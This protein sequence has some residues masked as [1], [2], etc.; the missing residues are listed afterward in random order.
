MVVRQRQKQQLLSPSYY[1]LQMDCLHSSTSG[2]MTFSMSLFR[3]LVQF[4]EVHIHHVKP[5]T[6][7]QQL[8]NQNSQKM[9]NV[10]CKMRTLER[11]TLLLGSL[12]FRYCGKRALEHFP[13]EHGAR[14]SVLWLQRPKLQLYSKSENARG[15]PCPAPPLAKALE[16]KN[17]W[18]HNLA[19]Q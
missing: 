12:C 7:N 8:A 3:T 16:S 9:E 10:K 2:H 13:A 15:T 4:I 1:H 5:I 6:N 19:K 17:W 14:N 11:S 18:V